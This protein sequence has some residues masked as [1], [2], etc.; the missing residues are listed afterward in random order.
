MDVQLKGIGKKFR[1]NW[2]FRNITYK[3][4]TGGKYA[5]LGKNGSGKSTLLQIISG[6]MLP[7]EGEVQYSNDTGQMDSEIIY[8]K[9]TFA[10][11]YMTLFE[12]LTLGE[13]LEVHMNFRTMKGN[14]DKDAVL[15]KMELSQHGQKKLIDLSSGM[16][17]RVKLGLALMTESDIILLDEPLSNLDEHGRKWYHRMVNEFIGNR[18]TIVCSNNQAEEYNFCTEVL[19]L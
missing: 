7:S 5:I 4:Q 10:A 14:F 9:L 3:F 6:I 11:P 12:Q 19:S 18:T 17:Q 16:K 13:Q 15:A 8:N 2:V 1:K